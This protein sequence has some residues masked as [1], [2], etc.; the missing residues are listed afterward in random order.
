MIFF[1]RLTS[2]D[3]YIQANPHAV[4]W[5]FFKHLGILTALNPVRY[6]MTAMRGQ[7]HNFY[8]G[9]YRFTTFKKTGPKKNMLGKCD[10]F[11]A[12]RT[13]PVWFFYL[14]GSVSLTDFFQL[15]GS[16]GIPYQHKKKDQIQWFLNRQY[17]DIN[18]KLPKTCGGSVQ[19]SLSSISSLLHVFLNKEIITA[20]L[21]HQN[22]P[23][24][25]A[26]KI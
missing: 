8:S 21:D 4:S 16:T 19:M 20:L 3:S 6:C 22:W 9:T 11:R 5:F 17:F 7:I 24:L 25:N 26:F 18:Y 13:W 23:H 12:N 2:I 1:W 10:L 14:Q 15:E